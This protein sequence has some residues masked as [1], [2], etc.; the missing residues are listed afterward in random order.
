MK[1]EQAMQLADTGKQV[2]RPGKCWWVTT[3]IIGDCKHRVSVGG[4]TSASFVHIYEPDP[5]YDEDVEDTKARDWQEG[6]WC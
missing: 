6:T 2:C 1:F 5:T 4:E 3:L